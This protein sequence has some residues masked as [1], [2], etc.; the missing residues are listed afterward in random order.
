MGGRNAV[1]DTAT[2]ARADGDFRWVAEI[3]THMLRMDPNDQHAR[4]LK[5]DALRQLGYRAVNPI[6]RNNYLMGAS[7]L[8]G[9][10]DHDAL[11]KTLRGMGNPD[12]AVTMPNPLL[13]RAFATRLNPER[14]RGIH[15]RVNIRCTDSGSDYGLAIR[16]DVVELLADPPSD[17][18]LAIQT[19]E[20]MLRGLLT[21]RVSWPRALE[22]GSTTLTRGTTDDV[23]RFWSLFDP[24]ASEIPA[25]ALR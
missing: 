22:D 7:E 14:S 2:Q 8:D 4:E 20:P 11:L 6:W 21:G 18:T 15:L 1:I 16:S 25:V 17:A 13:L 5:A 10:L 3:L 23:S 24:P 19:T 12:V 9:T